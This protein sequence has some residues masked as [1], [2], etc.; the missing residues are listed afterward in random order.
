[1]DDQKHNDAHQHSNENKKKHE[2]KGEKG[3]SELDQLKDQNEKLIRAYAEKENEI[4]RVKQDCQSDIRYAKSKIAR[5][6]LDIADNLKRAA[7]II[8]KDFKNRQSDEQIKNLLSGI[9]MTEQSFLKALEKNGITR[10]RS[11]G[12]R[13]DPNL[14]QIIQQVPSA[15]KDPGTIIDEVQAGYMI[16]DKVLREAMVVIAK[17]PDKKEQDEQSSSKD[18]TPDEEE[19]NQESDDEAKH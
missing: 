9:E 15:E 19:D 1:M 3:K 16:D 18:D 6:F 13:M 10:I 2:S 11:I 4:K 5:D 12:E 7:Q 14:H 17:E 8:N